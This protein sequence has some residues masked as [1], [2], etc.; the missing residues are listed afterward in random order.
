M[1]RKG[2]GSPVI[3]ESVASTPDD[4]F[5]FYVTKEQQIDSDLILV[6]LF[7]LDGERN[8]LAGFCCQR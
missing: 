4:R 6:N 8:G 5:F 2:R 1:C 3:K 7:V